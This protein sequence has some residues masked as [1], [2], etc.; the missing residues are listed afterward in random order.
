MGAAVAAR[1]LLPAAITLRTEDL[2]VM[3]RSDAQTRK[4]PSDAARAALGPG[5]ERY[6]AMGAGSQCE[7]RAAATEP[8][9]WNALEDWV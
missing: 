5:L 6:H 9:I 8:E 4:L 7:V 1:L 2:R 3:Q